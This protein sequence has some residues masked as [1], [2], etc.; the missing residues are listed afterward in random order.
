VSEAAF[1]RRNKPD[2]ERLEG[3]AAKLDGLGG[4]LTG[5]D[6]FAFISLYR[7]VTGDLARAR[8]IQA[9]PEV[10]DYLNGLVGRVHF[11]VYA[12]RTYPFAKFLDFFRRDFP[13]AVR[14]SWRQT[15]AS[16]L[17]L[18]VP[19]IGAYLA[20]RANPH[21][22]TAFAP[23]GYAEQLE[24]SVGQGFGTQDRPAG[25]NVLMNSFYIA[26][27]VYV[28]ILAFATGTL[29]GLGS[30]LVL[31][32]NGMLLG[33]T[34]GVIAARGLQLPF[35]SF[36]AS[37]GGI[38]LGAIVLAGAAGLRIGLAVL[39]PGMLPRGRALAVAAKDAGLL[40]GG[41]V[42]LLVL[43]AAIEAWISPSSLPP[44]AKLSLGAVNLAALLAYLVFAG[45]PAV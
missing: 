17:L 22:D 23:P 10:I 39:S 5:R 29:L 38:E 44:A 19:A 11:R 34:A 30:V 41:V 6:L 12:T 9:R 25:T 24:K 33:G 37:H 26:N 1:L 28:A 32:I 40:M 21:L 3:Y 20:V 15:L 45:R 13:R 7:K 36:V 42:T 27:N 14:R 16:A 8:T 2:W 4:G 18:I 43:A 31:G 35:W